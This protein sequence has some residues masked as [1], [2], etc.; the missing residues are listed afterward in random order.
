MFLGTPPFYT[1]S[2]YSLIKLIIKEPV[3]YPDNMSPE[4]KSFLKGL[5]NKTPSERLTWPELLKHPFIAET[6]PEKSDRKRRLEKYNV[7]ADIEMKKTLAT[8][9]DSS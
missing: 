8:S 3:K 1:N 9:D 5:L 6:D 2:I 7:W 4:F